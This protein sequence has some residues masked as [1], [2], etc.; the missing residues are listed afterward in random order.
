MPYE[1]TLKE[2]PM[3]YARGSALEGETATVVARQF[4]SSEDGEAFF[5]RMDGWPSTIIAAL[6]PEG[7]VA[8]PNV[9]H[10]VALIRT[11]LT[12]T[13]Y[14]NEL[15]QIMRIRS[16][17]ALDQGQE[18][19]ESD[20]ADVIELQF[21]GLQVPPDVGL[22]VVFSYQWRKGL[23]FD[24][25]PFHNSAYER[26]YDLGQL[27]GAAFAYIMNQTPFRLTEQDWEFV[28]QSGWFPFTSL[29]LDLRRSLLEFGRSRMEIDLLQPK[30]KKFLETD[31][32][33][34]VESWSR[35][36]P[37]AAH[38]DLLKHAA[39]EFAEGD[40][41]SAISL[42]MPRIEGLMRDVHASVA[43]Q[44]KASPR[45]LTERL[46]DGRR[47]ELHEYSWLLPA[48]FI[49]FLYEWYFAN[50]QPG[51]STKF[52]RHSVAHG[53]ASMTDFNEKTACVAFLTLDQM[54]WL[55]P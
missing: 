54:F 16:A 15:K 27:L 30:V 43:A 38:I 44:E 1:I 11:D 53:V 5:K 7:G 22:I 12:A 3:G 26:P 37:Y 14:I 10:L 47:A 32:T 34:L 18:I 49:Q 13:V 33:R 42:V 52:S 46:L 36:A 48:R 29:P 4:L 6:P 17:G 23:F 40:F 45:N 41:M 31:L 35:K 55:L 39:D 25:S 19:R 28:F 21:E 50:F 20:I 24:F 2:K 9:D 51:Q 8:P